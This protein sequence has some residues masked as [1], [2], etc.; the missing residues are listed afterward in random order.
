M[1][2]LIA[3]QWFLFL[4]PGLLMLVGKEKFTSLGFT[5]K[6]LP[7]QILTGV[8]V[9]AAMSAVLTVLP[10][11][12]G[13]R[14]MIG[15]TN[16]THPWQFAYEFLYAV[17]G[18]ALAEELIFR[19]Y[20]FHKLLELKNSKAFAVVVS[21]ALFGLFHIFNGLSIQIIIT[22]L[23]GVFYCLCREKIRNCTIFSLILAHGLYDAMIV[24]WVG[25]L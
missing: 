7:R 17:S 19:G 20:I 14:G 15:S 10:V 4:I 8:C 23:I 25:I 1:V 16:Y 24:L 5:K 18:V 3:S 21:S 2:L 9:A 13:L 12:L 6:K 11:L 22:A